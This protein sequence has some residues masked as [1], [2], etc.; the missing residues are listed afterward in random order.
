MPVN[1]VNIYCSNRSYLVV[2]SSVNYRKSLYYFEFYLNRKGLPEHILGHRFLHAS[3]CYGNHYLTINI[4]V[5]YMGQY[6]VVLRG[7]IHNK[8][9]FRGGGA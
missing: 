3:A 9:H 2:R 7:T 4:P 1:P 6:E 5:V 8:G